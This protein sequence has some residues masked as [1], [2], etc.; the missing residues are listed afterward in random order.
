MGLLSEARLRIVVAS[1]RVAECDEEPETVSLETRG[2]DVFEMGRDEDGFA[3]ESSPEAWLL[4]GHLRMMTAGEG[5]CSSRLG[6]V[7]SV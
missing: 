7:E 2:F 3:W 4:E 1:S 5:P 6:W